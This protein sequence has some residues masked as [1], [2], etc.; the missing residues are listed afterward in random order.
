M[1]TEHK[2]KLERWDEVIRICVFKAKIEVDY[3]Q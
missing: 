3:V 2:V 1:K